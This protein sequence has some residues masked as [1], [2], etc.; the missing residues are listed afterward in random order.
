MRFYNSINQKMKE[1]AFIT[2]TNGFKD[3][4]FRLARR[5]LISNEE[6]EDALQEVLLRL[7]KNK[8]KMREY[9][10]VEAFAM[11]M[12]KNYCFDKLKAKESK[13]LKIVHSNYKDERKNNG[14]FARTTTYDYPA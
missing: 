3:K 2:L 6:A 12:T 4:L 10:N 9:N 5:L 13:N 14:W 7:W 8:A 11:T 1:S